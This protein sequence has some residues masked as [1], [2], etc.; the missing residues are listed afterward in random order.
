MSKPLP[1]AQRPGKRPK[2]T[3][4]NLHA[5]IVAA[6][7]DNQRRIEDGLQYVKIKGKVISIQDTAAIEEILYGND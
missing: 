6:D 2:K 4:L 7:K 5:D 3:A 1:K